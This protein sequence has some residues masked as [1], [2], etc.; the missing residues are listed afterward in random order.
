[1]KSA[2]LA[3][4]ALGALVH[5]RGVQAALNCPS[6]Y[7]PGT[8]DPSTYVATEG[9]TPTCFPV[10][11]DARIHVGPSHG[12]HG[13]DGGLWACPQTSCYSAD[14]NE[15]I[16][17][18]EETSS[19]TTYENC[20]LKVQECFDQHYRD[21]ASSVGDAC[22]QAEVLDRC[23]TESGCSAD[24]LRAEN[25]HQLAECRSGGNGIKVAPVVLG[26]AGALAAVGLGVYTWRKRQ[27]GD[28]V[29]LKGPNANNSNNR[30]GDDASADDIV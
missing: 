25:D 28:L 6:G 19:P 30:R 18:M 15:C 21:E 8:C 26:C 10:R 12:T 5:G 17:E 23:Y 14:Y 3:I 1:M 20:A 7:V 11:G 22:D 16:F 29:P 27:D 4:F 13:E 24:E 9:G 2:T